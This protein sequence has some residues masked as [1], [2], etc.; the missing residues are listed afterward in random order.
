MGTNL[1]NVKYVLLTL[2][3]PS[4]AVYVSTYC[5]SIIDVQNTT[6]V[7]VRFEVSIEDNN[8]TTDGDNNVNKTYFTFIR[9]GDT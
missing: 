6:N 7:K 8:A 5:E 9:L 2:L 4:V 3:S 1:I